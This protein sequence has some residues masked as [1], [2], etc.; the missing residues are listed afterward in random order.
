MR[1]IRNSCALVVWMAASSV[2]SGQI[3]TWTQAFPANSPQ[4]RNHH[5]MADDG[6][7]QKVLLF[8]GASQ[9]GPVLADTWEWDGTNWT[10]RVLTTK[11][12]A[13][14]C[15]GL[16]YDAAR[17]V[18]VLFGGFWDVPNDTWEWDGTNWTE[19]APVNAPSDRFSVVLTYD[20]RRSVTV[21]FGGEFAVGGSYVLNET[22]ELI[23]QPGADQD[24]DNAPDWCDNCPAAPNP[25]QR[26]SD[27]D[28]LGDVCDPC[29]DMDG[30][31]FGNPG[32][33]S[34]SCPTDNCPNTPNPDQA[35][36]DADG[37]GD[38]CD[39]CPNTYN[40]GQADAD[41]DGR[42]DACDPQ[43]FLHVA[44]TG[45]DASDGLCWAT[46]KR[47]VQAGLDAASADDQVWVA[48]G[49]YVERI[50]LKDGVGLY[51][52]FAGS[53]TTLAQ[54]NWTANRTVLDGDQQGSV[55]TAPEGA[56]V[57]T[58]IDG[59][60]IRNGWGGISCLSSSP[61][62]ANNTITG[63]IA[64]EGSG[65][66]IYCVAGSP[67]I[68]NNTVSGNTAPGGGGIFCGWRS[69]P[70]IANNMITGNTAFV[71]FHGASGGGIS[72]FYGSPT[73]VNNTIAG[74]MA[75]M[76]AGGGIS[77]GGC[78]PTIANNTIAGNISDRGG[79]ISCVVGSPTIA[80]NAITANSAI[81]YGG[82]IYCE[83]SSSAVADNTIT[84]NTAPGGGGFY[85]YEASPTIANTIIAFNSSGVG[86]EEP[87]LMSYNCVYGNAEY[88]YEGTDP[89]G[90]NGNISADPLF[91]RHP[92]DGGDG[93]GDNPDTPDVDEGVNDDYGDLHLRAGSPCI[94]AGDNAAVPIGVT[95][96]LAGRSRFFDDLATPD[97]GAGT[98]PIVDMGAYEFA[99]AV[100]ADLDGD[101]DV[102]LDDFSIF[103]AC[104]SGP[105]IPHNG[106]RTC[107][108]A[109]LDHD[110]AVDQV[111][112]GLFQRCYSGTGKL[113]DPNCTG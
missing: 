86:G 44:T 97:T 71:P 60:M 77:C 30:D 90:T 109:D 54:R 99:P 41:Q 58:R 21:L 98:P 74:N 57:T 102:D 8:G 110:G 91:V 9:A 81:Y 37:Y 63:N 55:V 56:T 43:M 62:I 47:T 113:A 28:G 105:A 45:D 31:G 39:N 70:T 48:A 27:G 89:T 107:Q 111:D 88:N 46:A 33:P 76:G 3:T 73:I 78:S 34:N 85:C 15:Y 93:W 108:T 61:T 25:D 26:D 64:A 11:P 94:D 95:T 35:D 84:G 51:G 66:G 82:G 69:S 12:S 19:R 32:F 83:S 72:C 22:W 29:T 75:V 101:G 24:G 53:E 40:P 1:K 14:N 7:R 68:A 96:D 20:S 106:T 16:A 49:T 50:T 112:F 5:A 4:A 36:G 2:V 59:F 100:P 17:G 65:G 104:A 52:G 18:T 79:G 80:N 67:T 42:G 23:G 6:Q 13:R 103:Q 92:S 38:A 10:Q 87:S